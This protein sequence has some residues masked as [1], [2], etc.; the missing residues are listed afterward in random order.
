MTELS[1][2]EAIELAGVIQGGMEAH[3]I[4]AQVALANDSDVNPN[5]NFDA[6]AI[7]EY[8]G[9]TSDPGAVYNLEITP[10]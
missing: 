8:A 5:A 7:P 1:Q 3:G 2:S 4:S 10:T 6:N 9:K